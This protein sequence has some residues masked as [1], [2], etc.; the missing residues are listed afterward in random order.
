MFIFALVITFGCKYKCLNLNVKIFTYKFLNF[1][2]Y[3]RL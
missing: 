1:F 3:E 2:V